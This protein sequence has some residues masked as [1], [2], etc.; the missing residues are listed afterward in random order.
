MSAIR[1][2]LTDEHLEQLRVKAREVGLSPEEMLRARVEAWLSQPDTDFL[3][4]ATYVL[5]KNTELYRRM[6]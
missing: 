3:E 2:E 6:S 4:A 5:E 1:I